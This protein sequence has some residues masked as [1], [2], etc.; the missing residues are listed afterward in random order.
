MSFVCDYCDK[1]FSTKGNLG[2]HMSGSKK[3]IQNRETEITYIYCSEDGC[4]FKTFT[5]QSMNRHKTKCEFALKNMTA[6]NTTLRTQ[7]QMLQELLDKERT[8]TTKTNITTNNVNKTT[9]N[10]KQNVSNTL[11]IDMRDN[12][13]REIMSPASELFDKIPNYI[14]ENF[15]KQHLLG[16]KQVIYDFISNMVNEKLYYACM[17]KSG[18][19]FI[20]KAQDGSI[21]TDV[22]ARILIDRI[23]EP[24]VESVEELA[25]QEIRKLAEHTK[26]MEDEEV[27]KKNN[28]SIKD[29]RVKTNSVKNIKNQ[30]KEIRKNLADKLY[31]PSKYLANYAD[32]PQRLLED[33]PSFREKLYLQEYVNTYTI[34]NV[35]RDMT[36]DE[37]DEIYSSVKEF[38]QFI[39][40]NF[41]VSNC[42][43]VYSYDP[44]QCK[45]YFYICKGDGKQDEDQSSG[46]EKD[47]RIE[48]EKCYSIHKLFMYKTDII[49]SSPSYYLD[50]DKNVIAQ[51]KNIDVFSNCMKKYITKYQ[52]LFLKV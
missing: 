36:E 10:N 21:K 19:N 34:D 39:I 18:S 47:L 12:I 23:Y 45:F 1:S 11:S 6:S 8:R 17:D 33:V 20:Y 4:D 40:H 35:Y 37:L 3:C 28:K 52:S 49:L 14:R 5:N 26:Y 22:Q 15:T 30:D 48:E 25:N 9:T 2:K 27:A 16:N 42:K 7:V 43:L 13:F 31:Y 41:L 32:E 38:V 29:I 46:S 44:A 51:I 24:L 50:I